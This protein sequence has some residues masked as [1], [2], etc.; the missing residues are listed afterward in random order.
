MASN[1]LE[2]VDVISES[3]PDIV[4]LDIMMP[5]LDGLG[6]LERLRRLRMRNSTQIIMLT[7]AW[8][9]ETTQMALALGA[10]YYML[11]PF[12]FGE[13][14]VRIRQL[15]SL[16]RQ[17]AAR[18]VRP[19]REPRAENSIESE[20]KSI[21]DSLG[22]PPH[23]YGYQYLI[24][25]SALVANDL[26]LINSMNRDVY[27]SIARKFSTTPACAER[28]IRNAVEA[29]WNRGDI[30]RLYKLFGCKISDRKPKPSNSE[31]IMTVVNQYWNRRSF[32]GF[33]DSALSKRS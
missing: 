28:S 15:Q 4:L 17:N 22:V 6:V 33:A 26:S 20:V 1:G 27:P 5:Y 24:Y 30:E 29:T 12:D 7:A 11:K 31:F 13:L 21:I 19:A 9:Y 3:K 2:A 32:G 10:D 16:K 14:V 18:H 8:N 25:A 23:L